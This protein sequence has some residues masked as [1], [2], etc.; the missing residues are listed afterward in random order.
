MINPTGDQPLLALV[1]RAAGISPVRFLGPTER[2]TYENAARD[3]V[4]F[5][6]EVDRLDAM[7]KSIE[8]SFAATRDEL[9]AVRT[10]SE[11][12]ASAVDEI[13]AVPQGT[14]PGS[15]A[16]PDLS[17]IE[18]QLTK[19]EAKIQA[20]SAD[21]TQLKAAQTETA[22]TKAVATDDIRLKRL[23]AATSLDLA[24]RQGEPFA[25]ALAAARQ[26]ADDAAA[27]KPLEGFAASGVPSVAALSN[28]LLTL[29]PQLG[30]APDS[31]SQGSGWL[32]RLRTSAA[33]LV[34]IRH[35]DTIAG[36]DTT[37]IVARVTVAARRNDITA[38]KRELS[39]LPQAE[40]A[41]VQPWIDKT[42]AC[43]AARAASRQFAE[44]AMTALV[45][46]AP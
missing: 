1:E 20:L 25:S 23:V 33:R 32:D 29:L 44:N 27:L 38:A 13:K 24:V 6:G 2:D 45:K 31:P 18:G 43:D 21:N 14:S 15:T 26:F 28:E 3:A 42:D 39:A 36:H 11:R 46:P 40:R 37:A 10:K 7:E 35:T 8:K 17:A 30:V 9:A 16:L 19:L 5:Q 41:K 34:K 4:R 12:T 22:G